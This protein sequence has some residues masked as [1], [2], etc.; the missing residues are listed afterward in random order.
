MAQTRTCSH[1]TGAGLTEKDPHRGHWSPQDVLA[2]GADLWRG[3]SALLSFLIH[4][5]SETAH[6][7]RGE[8]AP[9]WAVSAFPLG[10]PLGLPLQKP[11]C[12]P[13]SLLTPKA[14]PTCLPEH[15]EV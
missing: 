14:D 1:R 4:T 6:A 10:L 15:A 13:E 8:G 5:R 7:P 3:C 9:D 12:E 11:V 2:T